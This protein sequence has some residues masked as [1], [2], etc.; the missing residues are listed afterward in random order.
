MKEK[1]ALCLAIGGGVGSYK[2]NDFFLIVLRDY[3]LNGE[4][5]G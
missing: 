1:F 4:K 3:N 2:R 5:Y